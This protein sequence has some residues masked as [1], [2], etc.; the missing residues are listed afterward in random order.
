MHT[1]TA[2]FCHEYCAQISSSIKERVI[3]DSLKGASVKALVQPG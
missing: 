1:L 3:L 2:A